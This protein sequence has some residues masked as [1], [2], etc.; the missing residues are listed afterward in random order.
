MCVWNGNTPWLF[1][2]MSRGSS[3]SILCC[4]CCCFCCYWDSR[5]LFSPAAAAAAVTTSFSSG[6]FFSCTVKV[7]LHCHQ[8]NDNFM[9]W[10]I[11]AYNLLD[12]K[13]Q[14]FF[15][16]SMSTIMIKL[17]LKDH[18][19]YCSKSTQVSEEETPQNNHKEEDASIQSI[20][21]ILDWIITN[22]FWYWSLLMSGECPLVKYTSV[23]GGLKKKNWEFIKHIPHWVCVLSPSFDNKDF[24]FPWGK[25]SIIPYIVVLEELQTF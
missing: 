13:L 12:L 6:K 16:F 21:S 9:L 18:Q 2:S 4:C 8:H 1:Y 10:W 22:S 24:Y 23:C 14:C 3:C 15:F 7:N 11:T 5:V 17:S 25:L 19:R 20:H